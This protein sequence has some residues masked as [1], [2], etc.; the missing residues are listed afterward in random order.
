MHYGPNVKIG[1]YAQ[2]QAEKLDGKLTVFDTIDRHATGD[3]RMRVRALLGAFLFSGDDVY[4]KVSVLSGG[5]KSRLALAHLL[6]EPCNLL[7]LDEPT[8]H[9]DM[10]SK[11]VLKEALQNYSGTLIIVSHDRDFLQ[12]LTNKVFHFRHQQ[13]KENI[14]DIYEFLRNQKLQSLQELEKKQTIQPVANRS[15][16]P[17]GNPQNG[18]EMKKLEKRISSAEKKIEALETDLT[19]TEKKLSDPGRLTEE[20]MK[21]LSFHY[22]EQKKLLDEEMEKWSRLLEERSK[23]GN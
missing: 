19:E 14:G 7:V 6:L 12:G 2:Q 9:L 21:K 22:G 15:V 17:A 13:A 11:D 23:A 3:M 16:T 5:E 8:N 1:Y 4:K 20:E 18:R 10:R